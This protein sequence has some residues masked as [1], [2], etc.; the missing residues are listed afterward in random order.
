MRNNELTT[1]IEVVD[2]DDN[3]IGTSKVAARKVN[4][5][6]DLFW[7]TPKFVGS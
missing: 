1:G 7:Y 4:K 3:V 5:L 2:K 6:I